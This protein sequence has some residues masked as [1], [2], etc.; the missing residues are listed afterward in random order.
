MRTIDAFFL[1]LQSSFVV[2]FGFEYS[3]DGRF[4]NLIIGMANAACVTRTILKLVLR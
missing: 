3:K 4:N 2:I 1:V